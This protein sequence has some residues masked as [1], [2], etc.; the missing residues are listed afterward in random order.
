MYFFLRIVRT[1]TT[2]DAKPRAAFHE[3]KV[4]SMTSTY[5]P[6]RRRLSCSLCGPIGWGRRMVT[7][8]RFAPKKSQIGAKIV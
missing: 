5:T 2:S 8:Q 3:G 7:F 4:S 6:Y 1:P